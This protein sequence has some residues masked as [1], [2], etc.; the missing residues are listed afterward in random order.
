MFS[1]PVYVQFAELLET[2]QLP[3]RAR[4]VYSK[5]LEINPTQAKACEWLATLEAEEEGDKPSPL[6]SLLFGGTG[7]LSGDDL[8][9]FFGWRKPGHLRQLGLPSLGTQSNLPTAAEFSAPGVLAA[10]SEGVMNPP[11]P[12]QSR[13]RLDWDSYRG[14]CQRVL[15]RDGW[16]CQRCG[17]S[18][19]LQV[20][21]MQPRGM[22]GGDVEENLITLCS[23]CH[24]Q[25]HLGAETAS[26][27]ERGME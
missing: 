27:P 15:Q 13:L 11:V 3:V 22:L 26:R 4:A 17:S 25:I 19:D 20:H 18:Q 16:R 6:I 24:R 14:L 23:R 10:D 2:M 8:C 21:H 7:L 5:L 12:R 1:E 9:G